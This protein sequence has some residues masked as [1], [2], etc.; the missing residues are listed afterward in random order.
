MSQSKVIK[1]TAVPTMRINRSP[2]SISAAR[3][4]P[5]YTT[6]TRNVRRSPGRRNQFVCLSRCASQGGGWM[7]FAV[8]PGLR[9]LLALRDLPHL[10]DDFGGAGEPLFGRFPVLEEHP[11]RVG[12]RLRGLAVAAVD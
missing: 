7:S 3:V 6:A 1:R 9:R 12:P 10:A 2:G 8:A 5:P 4:T 11:L